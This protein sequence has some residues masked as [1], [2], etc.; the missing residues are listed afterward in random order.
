MKKFFIL[1]SIVLHISLFAQKNA[2]NNW[3]F[4]DRCGVNFNT[5]IPIALNDG[6]INQQEGVSTISNQNGELL[7]YSDG[8][9][10]W[11]KNHQAMPNANGDLD[12]HSSSTQSSIIAPNL[13]N[14][15]KFYIFTIDELA[16]SNGLKY[17]TVDMTLQGNGTVSN[18]LG[19]VM[20][21]EKNISLVSPIAEKITIILKANNI[22][23]WVIVHGWGNNN[24]YVFEVTASG[25]NT[26][27]QTFSVGDIH[28]GNTINTVGYMKS[29]M[30]GDKLALV[31]RTTNKVNLFDFNR[32]TGEI[33]NPIN[34]TPFNSLLDGLEFSFDEKYLFIG[35]ETTISK[36][37]I[38]DQ[39]HTELYFDDNTIFNPQNSVVRALQIGPDGNI[40][41]SVRYNDYLSMIDPNY[42]FVRS[43]EVFLDVD[44][45]GRHCRFGLP[46][47]FFYKGF[48]FVTGSEVDTTICEGDSIYLENTYQTVTGTYYDTTQSYQ[49]WDS[50]INTYLEVLP[51]LA[52]PTITENTG[53]LTSS[54]ANNYQWYYNGS[55][56]SGA[57]SQDYQPFTSGAYQVAIE[58]TNS[59]VSFSEEYNFVYVGINELENNFLIYPNPINDKLFIKSNKYFKIELINLNGQQVVVDNN[60]TKQKKVE[61]SNI[62]SGVYI[63]RI[64]TNN[65]TIIRKIIKQ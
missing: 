50:I 28:S 27:Y 64:I 61:M 9:T 19:D 42:N 63:L 59:C 54:S 15:T 1:I 34:I 58:N 46:D 48:R 16:G 5:G 53:V 31:N 60:K 49:G 56:I 20:T 22:D 24:F 41:V 25:V 65:A 38:S 13:S 21:T 26:S 51:V 35:G 57:T 43:K 3:Y 29:S 8:I 14:D 36:Y 6:V 55:L 45:T 33:S 40:Y 39:T 10:I 4:G 30:N 47:I 17:S 7:F 23:Y 2:G 11:D 32:Y 62:K 44:N 12:G 37:K 52:T 18:P